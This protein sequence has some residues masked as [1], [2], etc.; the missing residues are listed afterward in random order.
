[1]SNLTFHTNPAYAASV[2]LL[3]RL[4]VLMRDGKDDEEG[5]RIREAMEAPWYKLSDEEQ[6]RING[7]SADLKTLEPNSPIRHPAAPVVRP[8]DFRQALGEAYGTG[9]WEVALELLRTRPECISLDQATYLR[10]RCWEELGDIETARLFYDFGAQFNDNLEAAR[11]LFLFRH[12]RMS[13]ARQHAL[14]VAD[15]GD[16]ASTDL[17][18]VA[19]QVVFSDSR[20]QDTDQRMRDLQV[21]AHLLSGSLTQTDVNDATHS[22]TLALLGLCYH[23]LGRKVE[24]AQ[25]YDQ[26]IAIDPHDDRLLVARGLLDYDVNPERA[27]NDF[28]TAVAHQTHLVWPYAFLAHSAL[29]SRDFNSAIVMTQNAIA[30]TN[31]ASHRAQLLEWWGIA[32]TGVGRPWNEIRSAFQ[33][34]IMLAPHNTRIYDNYLR[35]EQAVE[36][37]NDLTQTRWDMPELQTDDWVDSWIRREQSQLLPEVTA[38]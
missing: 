19:G 9:N 25:I 29:K 2:E 11:L 35:F 26:A 36:L 33:T 7:M 28:K 30:R 10:S 20:A 14:S 1:M 21:A 17:R 13:E 12:G 27:M 34:A 32:A 22:V 24:A 31:N 18:R 23:Q 15:R 6:E 8:M 37:S 5:D 3:H 4:H 38:A 16:V